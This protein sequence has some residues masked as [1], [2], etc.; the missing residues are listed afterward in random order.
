M[1]VPMNTKKC[2]IAGKMGGLTTEEYTENFE[3]GKKEVAAMGMEPIS[4]AD[5]PHDHDR[6][7]TSYM[8]ED[9]IAMLGCDAVYALRNWR[10]SPGARVEINLALEM[11]M[12]VIHQP[13]RKN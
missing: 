9:L 2:Y 7:W 1:F 8:K 13:M 4:P 11:G 12:Q 5:L 6:T 10:H 3:I